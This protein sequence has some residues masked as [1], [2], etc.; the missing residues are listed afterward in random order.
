MPDFDAIDQLVKR[1][2]EIPKPEAKL[3]F[4]LLRWGRRRNEAALIYSIPNHREPKQPYEKGITKSELSKAFAQLE[5]SGEFSREW[6]NREMEACAKE[7]G[8]NFTTI[9]GLMI[10][11]DQATYKR[12]RYVRR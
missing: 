5:R 11:L 12:A 6:F 7:G 2:A 4:R 9:G 1:Q 3:P 8:C 10:S